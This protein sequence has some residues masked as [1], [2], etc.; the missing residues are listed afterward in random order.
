[1]SDKQT[2]YL[3]EQAQTVALADPKLVFVGEQYSHDNE[4]TQII[5]KGG[6]EFKNVQTYNLNSYPTAPTAPQASEYKKPEDYDKAQEK[7]SKEQEKYTKQTAHLEELKEQGK[8][9][10][11]AKIGDSNVRMYYKEVATK[12]TKGNEQLI[13]DLTAKKKRNN[14]LA[15]EKT[16]EGLKELLRTEQLPQSAFTADEETAMYFFML[17]K[18][19]RHNYKAVGLKENDYYGYL[20]DDKKLKIASSLTE[21]QKTVVR[22][23]YLYSHLTDGT[24]T[25]GNEKGGMLLAFSKQHLPEKTEEIVSVQKEEYGKK[26]ARLDERIAELEKA[27][28]KAKADAKA[29]KGEQTSKTEKAPKTAET[30]VKKGADA[31]APKSEATKP[32]GK[33]Q[34]KATQ[35]EKKEAKATPQADKV[36]IVGIPKAQPKAK[37]VAV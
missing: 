25:V 24:R 27:E 11:Y 7:Y 36:L 12:D 19:R 2:A 30:A 37:A 10:V 23:D 6:Y 26:N 32:K 33:G 17:T 21:E 15:D 14:E 13:S 34:P 5:K 9:R 20:T 18:L 28:K 35:S 31:T 29:K 3:V 1:L 16:A 4:A 22:R 8:I